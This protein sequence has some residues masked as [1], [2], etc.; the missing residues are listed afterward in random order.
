MIDLDRPI[1]VHEGHEGGRFRP[2]KRAHWRGTIEAYWNLNP[3]L[4]LADMRN[5]VRA[6]DQKGFQNI[7][8]TVALLPYV[9]R[10]D[11]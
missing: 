5:L 8:G 7:G 1:S 3:H 9:V 2:K 11:A 6:L 10:P 4:S